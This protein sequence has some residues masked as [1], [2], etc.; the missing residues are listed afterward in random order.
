MLWHQGRSRSGTRASYNFSNATLFCRAVSFI[1]SRCGE[2]TRTRLASANSSAVRLN[3]ALMG[4]RPFFLWLPDR[5]RRGLRTLTAQPLGA[6]TDQSA[7]LP[8]PSLAFAPCPLTSPAKDATFKSPNAAKESVGGS[9]F[10]LVAAP[11]PVCLRPTPRCHAA[12][13]LRLLGSPKRETVRGL[14]SPCSRSLWSDKP[15]EGP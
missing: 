3:P 4:R 11:N 8:F 9:N 1:R 10:P 12:C 2:S 14:P 6:P 13:P 7:S 15:D 5:R